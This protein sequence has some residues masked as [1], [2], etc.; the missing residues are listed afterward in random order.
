[1]C[2]A[3]LFYQNRQDHQFFSKFLVKFL[4]N[5]PCM[6]NYR[7]VL[8]RRCFPM[9]FMKFLRTPFFTEHLYSGGSF[10]Q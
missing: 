7:L 1:M 4:R 6:A 2:E 9:K 5:R 10:W 8:Q 3:D